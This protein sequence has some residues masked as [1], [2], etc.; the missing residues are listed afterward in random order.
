[1]TYIMIM[2]LF[3]V[4]LLVLMSLY[5]HS[6]SYE[7]DD[8]QVLERISTENGIIEI[9]DDACKEGLPHTTNSE[10]IRMTREKYESR[11][12]DSLLVHERVH[13]DQKRNPLKWY[14]FYKQFWDYDIIKDS[15]S[16]VSEYTEKLR[17]NPDTSDAPWAVWRK[18]YVFFPYSTGSLKF[19]EVR[20]WDLQEKR[21]VGI[22]ESWKAQFCDGTNCPQQYEHPHEISAEYLTNRSRDSGKANAEPEAVRQLF[23][24][25]K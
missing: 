2:G 22:P 6:I 19:A 1:M 21:E 8:C 9:V 10:T 17:P 25:Y 24:W 11:G 15:P 5:L 12:L 3:I 14:R 7:S 13:L 4:V 23:K 20:V 18:R 16:P